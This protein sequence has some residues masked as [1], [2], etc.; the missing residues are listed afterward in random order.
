MVKMPFVFFG[1]NN[2]FF[3]HNKLDKLI[4]GLFMDIRDKRML[5]CLAYYTLLI[6]SLGLSV[7]FCIA[8][9]TYA[10]P[11]WAMIIYYVWTAIAIGVLL[12]DAYCM[13]IKGSKYISGLVL[14]FLAISAV[15]MSMVLYFVLA[16]GIAAIPAGDVAMYE[17]LMAL[18]GGI[19]LF[20][21]ATFMVG[22][23]N[24]QYDLD[25][26]EMK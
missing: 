13:F 24:I 26:E 6:I 21:I 14:Y 15:I 3:A 25:I 19:T 7:L 23:W 10:V 11:V 4:G 1:I 12:Y 5:S 17:V 2:I 16:G 9:A 20:T 18:S 8:L 22:E